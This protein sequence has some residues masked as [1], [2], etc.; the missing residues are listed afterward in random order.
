MRLRPV[1][2]L[3]FLIIALA[4]WALI[5]VGLAAAVILYAQTD[6]AASADVIVVLGSGLRA[7]G[8]PGPALI[9]RS[10][11]GAEL[12]RAGFAP[13]VICAGGLGQ[14]M[15]R[16]EAHACRQILIDNGVPEAAVLLEERSRSTEENALYTREIMDAN[17]WA[18]ALV[19]SDGYHLLRVAW[20]FGDMGLDIYTSRPAGNPATY[21]Y[22]SA[23]LREVVALH[24]QAF[25]TIFGLPVTYVPWV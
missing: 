10:E 23:V 19:V 17:D 13:T 9:R 2:L 12:W 5:A 20:I 15:V 22:V 7:D 18:T 4:V 3:R 24:W 6:R 14:G 1:H 11:R 16:S 8:R 21:D 25:K